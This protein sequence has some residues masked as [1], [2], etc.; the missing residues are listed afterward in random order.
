MKVPVALFVG[1][2]DWLATEADISINLRPKLPNIIY[3]QD[4]TNW[5]H[6]DFVWGTHANKILYKNVIKLMQ[7]TQP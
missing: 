4:I 7:G 2:S 3:D 5:N 1:E 6:M